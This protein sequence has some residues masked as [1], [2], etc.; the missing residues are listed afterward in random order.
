[1]CAYPL[2]LYHSILRF[3]Y[4]KHSHEPTIDFTG[5]DSQQ[6]LLNYLHFFL[7]FREIIHLFYSASIYRHLQPV[8]LD[9]C[10]FH[11]L[12]SDVWQCLMP[13]A[14]RRVLICYLHRENK[15]KCYNS[16]TENTVNLKLD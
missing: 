7:L 5:F 2:S 16:F 9:T 12:S 14:E 11:Y 10:L 8:T 4:A 6:V 13:E 3:L 15:R 1:M